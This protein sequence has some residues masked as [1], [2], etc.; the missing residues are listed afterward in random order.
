MIYSNLTK[1]SKPYTF[2]LAAKYPLSYRGSD[3]L[4]MIDE[5]PSHTFVCSFEAERKKEVKTRGINTVCEE[6]RANLSPLRTYSEA[7][8]RRKRKAHDSQT[9]M[10]QSPQSSQTST[11]ASEDNSPSKIGAKSEIIDLLE[12]I[13]AE[14]LLIE[15]DEMC[16]ADDL[17]S[18]NHEPWLVEQSQN[19]QENE[20]SV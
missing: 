11:T 6:N 20:V 4:K 8:Y 19:I 10:S 13:S 7:S 1:K 9:S 18:L 2:P 3:R 5:N 16:S 14:Q 12:E 17:D 15:P